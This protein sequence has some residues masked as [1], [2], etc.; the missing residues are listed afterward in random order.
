MVGEPQTQPGPANPPRIDDPLAGVREAIVKL[1]AIAAATEQPVHRDG[2]LVR[3][4]R[5]LERL[6][7]IGR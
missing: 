7:G 4:A 2:P 5:Q 3:A 6:L 1:R